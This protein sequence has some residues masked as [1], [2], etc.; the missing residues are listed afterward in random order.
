MIAC[1]LEKWGIDSHVLSRAPRNALKLGI[2]RCD[3]VFQI[4][5]TRMIRYAARWR[6]IVEEVTQD[7]QGWIGAHELLQ[8]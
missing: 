3:A 2:Y 1:I 8:R 6:W 4:V 7:R 5:I